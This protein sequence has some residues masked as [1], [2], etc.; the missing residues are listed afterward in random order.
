MKMLAP[1]NQAESTNHII[2]EGTK[3]AIADHLFNDAY[4]PIKN[5]QNSNTE[6]S[7]IKGVKEVKGC[8]PQAGGS[9]VFDDIYSSTAKPDK[10]SGKPPASD[11]AYDTHKP[12]K[13]PQIDGGLKDKDRLGDTQSQSEESTAL[14]NLKDK[15]RAAVEAG[16]K[17]KILDK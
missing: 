9:V 16:G 15:L 1:E 4:G 3:G 17:G 11:E 14:R 8:L 13:K 6:S 7:T 12:I 2:K 5:Q 10:F